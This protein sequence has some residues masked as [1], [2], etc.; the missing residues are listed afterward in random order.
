MAK[1]STIDPL[2]LPPPRVI[3]LPTGR[4][5]MIM[6]TH[7]LVRILRGKRPQDK[8]MFLEGLASVL[9]VEFFH[10]SGYWTTLLEEFKHDAGL[11]WLKQKIE[12][13]NP[14]W[15]TYNN[16]GHTVSLDEKKDTLNDD[17][18]ARADQPVHAYILHHL[19]SKEA[20][21]A[22]KAHGDAKF[23]DWRPLVKELED[24]QWFRINWLWNLMKDGGE[25][26]KGAKTKMAFQVFSDWIKYSEPSVWNKEDMASKY[27]EAQKQASP[28]DWKRLETELKVSSS[29]NSIKCAECPMRLRMLQGL[30]RQHARRN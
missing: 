5:Q 1:K 9:P 30:K 2:S 14:R 23:Y 7:H 29:R 25:K 15:R 6:S 27:Q 24:A 13:D 22:W 12:H 3:T 16:Y 19:G 8:V 18:Y 20:D 26:K 4:E 10:G 11:I 21:E 17:T 28:A